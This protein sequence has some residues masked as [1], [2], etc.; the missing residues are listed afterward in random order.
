[1]GGGGGGGGGGQGP[2]ESHSPPHPNPLPAGERECAEFVAL[3]FHMRQEPVGDVV[4]AELPVIDLAVL[5]G[6]LLGGENLQVLLLRADAFVQ[7][8]GFLQRHDAVV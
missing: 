2:I 7:R 5:G 1:G 8:P 3:S 6:T 4:D